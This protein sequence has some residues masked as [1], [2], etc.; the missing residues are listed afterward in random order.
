MLV[1]VWH[2]SSS[3]SLL[4]SSEGGPGLL[5][6][7]A[8]EP[9]VPA[10]PA[11]EGDGSEEGGRL[12]LLGLHRLHRPNPHPHICPAEAFYT[13]QGEWRESPITSSCETS[14]SV[15]SLSLVVS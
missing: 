15:A 7:L 9:V 3:A 11:G 1:H 12:G 8:G 4:S 6:A 13:V 14:I 2:V 10:E 5:R